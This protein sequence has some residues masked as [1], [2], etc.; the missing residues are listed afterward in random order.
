VSVT[1]VDTSSVDLGEAA[2]PLS[3]EEIDRA[4][5]LGE[6]FSIRASGISES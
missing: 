4:V 1:L 5:Q 3:L 2:Q 6:V